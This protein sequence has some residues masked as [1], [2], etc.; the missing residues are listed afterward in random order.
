MELAVCTWNLFHGRSRPATHADLASDF[1]AALGQ[2]PWDVCGLQEAPPWWTRELAETLGASARGVRTSLTRGAL[3]AAQ[4]AVHRRSPETI[5]V[6]GAAA[7]VL[8]VRPSAGEIVDHRVARLRRAPQRRTV[9][10]VRLRRSD[11]EHWWVANV[12]T[13]NR[14]ESAAA[15]DTI[16]ALAAVERWAGAEPAVLLG[17]LN[18][19]APQG[20]SRVHGWE[21]LHGHR[22]DHI[23]GR[24]VGAGHRGGGLAVV[25]A[26]AAAI[27]G[28]GRHGNAYAD[29]ARLPEGPELSDHRIVGLTVARRY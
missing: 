8:L 21:H 24:G 19:S 20:L 26:G 18:L 6:R 25:S 11:G 27:A 7:N 3:P 9:H 2:H 23:L 12:H 4:E 5:G 10:A 29:V 1:A 17:D 28:E 15:A 22:V 14:P 13:H 16:R